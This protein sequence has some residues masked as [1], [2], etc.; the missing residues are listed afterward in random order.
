[1]RLWWVLQLLAGFLIFTSHIVNRKFGLCISS[2]LYYSF[3][4]ICFSGW[5]L[6]LSYQKAPS[7]FQPWFFGI[8]CLTIFGFGGSILYFHESVHWYNMVGALL[9]VLGCFLVGL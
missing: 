3:V 1:M 9:A 7:F 5:M 4:S 6:P 2:Y 8:A